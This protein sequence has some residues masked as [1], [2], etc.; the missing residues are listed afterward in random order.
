MQKVIVAITGAS[1]A[2]YAQTLLQR[3][4][5][6]KEYIY[7]IALIVSECGKQVFVYE[8]GQ[9]A[10]DTLQTL[11]VQHFADNDFFAPCAS[12]SAHYDTMFVVPCS[13]GTLGR[14]AHGTADTLIARAA[15]VILK[16][17]RRLILLSRE[18]PYGSIHLTNMQQITSAGGIICPASPAFY[19]RPVSIDD[20]I[21][22]VIDRLLQLADVKVE[23]FEWGTDNEPIV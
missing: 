8:R 21:K 20:L 9:N 23:G 15:D 22:T 1:G 10:W 19:S 14:I 17:H 7:E 4:C 18:M 11:P 16:E 12:G 5:T 2:I 3:L 13:M 6:L